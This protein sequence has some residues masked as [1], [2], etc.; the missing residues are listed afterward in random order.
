MY[1]M[2]VQN[3]SAYIKANVILLTSNK[4]PK[5]EAEYYLTMIAWVLPP[6]LIE[7]HICIYH[8]PKETIV[9][10]VHHSY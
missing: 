3:H 10:P 1:L 6:Q 9:C 4:C 5:E 8:Q 2:I 7:S